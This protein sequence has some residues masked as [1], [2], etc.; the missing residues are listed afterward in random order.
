M[1][2]N[3]ITNPILRRLRKAN[4]EQYFQKKEVLSNNFHDNFKKGPSKL[5]P[6]LGNVTNRNFTVFLISHI[7]YVWSKY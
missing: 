5:E 1:G 6:I 7:E 3:T 2:D 4:F